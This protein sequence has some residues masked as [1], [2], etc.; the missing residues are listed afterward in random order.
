M[1]KKWLIIG[2]GVFVVLVGSFMTVKK[3][4][5]LAWGWWGTY[6]TS[7][8]LAL[9]GY[10]PV[11]YFT[12]DQPVPGSAEYSYDWGDATWQFASAENLTLFEQ[13]PAE[14]APQFG[15][16]CAFA[17]SKGFTADIAMDAWH[18]E[19][20]K[21]YV[22]ADQNVRDDWVAALGEGSLEASTENWA[23]R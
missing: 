19:A 2:L 17:A 20:G 5:P 23:K 16:F 7:S 15:G 22:F 18:V 1:M 13:N 8:E 3:V 12:D 21:L 4:S 9:Q 14:Y 6:N 11:S 10:D